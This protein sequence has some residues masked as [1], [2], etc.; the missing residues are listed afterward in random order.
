MADERLDGRNGKIW[1]LYCR[2]ISQEKLA[3]QFDLSQQR[4]SQIVSEIRESIPELSKDVHRR[5]HLEVLAEARAVLTQ[6]ALEDPVYA[7]EASDR[8]AAF[9]ELRAYLEREAKMLGLD[10]AE[11]I[12][13]TVTEVPLS[14]EALIAIE[15]AEQA[16]ERVRERIRG[17]RPA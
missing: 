7:L 1:R 13:H 5:Q 4:V 15:Q 17:R 16:A 8:M 3:E 2:G 14:P 6:L 10:E 11:K 9:R 12:D